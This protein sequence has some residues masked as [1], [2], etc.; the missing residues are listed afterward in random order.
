MGADRLVALPQGIDCERDDDAV[1]RPATTMLLQ[2]IEKA[3]PLRGVGVGG[4]LLLGIASGRVDEHG[5]FGEEPV[6]VARAADPAEVVVEVDGE[7][8]ARLPKGRGLARRRRPDDHVPGQFPQEAA[9]AQLAAPS[10]P[11]TSRNRAPTAA[12]ASSP[13]LGCSSGAAISA[14]NM[15]LARI[16]RRWAMTSQ[17]SQTMTNAADDRNTGG[18]RAERLVRPDADDRAEYPDDERKER[19]P[20]EGP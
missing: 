14:T 13:A 20:D 3:Q 17:T 6:A 9:P 7:I 12:T 8:E 10:S 4:A 18:R 1:Q 15:R 16:A 5:M 2:E 11:I 19:Q